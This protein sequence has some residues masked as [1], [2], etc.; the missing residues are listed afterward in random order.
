MLS[1][2]YHDEQAGE[3][4]LRYVVAYLYCFDEYLCR[5]TMS[6]HVLLLLAR[7]HDHHQAEEQ[8]CLCVGARVH[9]HHV[10]GVE[11]MPSDIPRRAI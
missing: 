9:D 2:G 1:L 5:C 11:A 7:E 4:F 3:N 6:V 8:R 10:E